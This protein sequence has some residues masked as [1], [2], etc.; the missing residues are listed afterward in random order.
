MNDATQQTSFEAIVF[1]ENKVHAYLEAVLQLEAVASKDWLTNK[2]DRSVTGKIAQQQ[3]VGSL[4]LPLS[5]F[6]TMTLDY[7]GKGGVAT[8]V[9]HAPAIALIDAAAGSRVAIAEALANL[10]FAPIDG[11]LSGV[12]LS[13]N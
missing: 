11:G 4:Q 12:S 6:G 13:A 1:D 10:V 5:N 2:V 7:R 8:A 9:G 3:N